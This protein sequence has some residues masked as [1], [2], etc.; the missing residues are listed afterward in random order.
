[1]TW[2]QAEFKFREEVHKFPKTTE[3]ELLQHDYNFTN[4]GDEPLIISGIKVSCSCTKFTYPNKPINP[5]EKGIIHVSFDTQDKSEFQN[6][7]LFIYSNAPKSPK[8]IRF[9]VLVAKV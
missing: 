3:G 1:L 6:R 5:G 9:K 8:K 4:V 2:S 7:V